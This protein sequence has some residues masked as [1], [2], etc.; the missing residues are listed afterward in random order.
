MN[1]ELENFRAEQKAAETECIQAYE[2]N[3]SARNLAF[4]VVSALQ[5]EAMDPRSQAETTPDRQMQ[6]LGLVRNRLW[7]VTV[8]CLRLEM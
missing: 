2:V 6:A 1:S 7:Y 4:N 3:S 5:E 8:I